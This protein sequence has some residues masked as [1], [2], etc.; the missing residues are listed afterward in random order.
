MEGTRGF[1]TRYKHGGCGDSV[2][3]KLRAPVVTNTALDVFNNFVNTLARV[4]PPTTT[5]KEQCQNLGTEVRRSTRFKEA[6]EAN[7]QPQL[8]PPT[9]ISVRSNAKTTDQK[10]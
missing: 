8:P 5:M 4:T 7:R 9:P 6:M 10:V 1:Q 2:P 3:E